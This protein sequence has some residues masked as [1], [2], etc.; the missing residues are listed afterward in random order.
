[1]GAAIYALAYFLQR[2]WIMPPAALVLAV[3][4]FF[5]YNYSLGT[6]DQLLADH[7]DTLSETLCKA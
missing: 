4:G 1:L 2:P 3:I 7:R 5:V 6:M